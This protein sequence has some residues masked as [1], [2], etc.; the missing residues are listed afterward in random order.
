MFG[1]LQRND[2]P[3]N[4]FSEYDP[5]KRHALEGSGHPMDFDETLEEIGKMI[6]Q[7]MREAIASKK[8]PAEEGDAAQKT[9][10]EPT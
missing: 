4:W 3:L 5:N 2:V 7:G 8:S 6:N 9:D 10:E 1:H